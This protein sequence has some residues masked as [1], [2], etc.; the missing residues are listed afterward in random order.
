MNLKT[1]FLEIL[2]GPQQLT[3]GPVQGTK[4]VKCSHN[5]PGFILFGVKGQQEQLQGHCEITDD[6]VKST[7]QCPAH[8]RCSTNR[9]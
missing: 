9:I 6:T 2:H 8:S 7:A 3:R 5:C 4:K 1:L